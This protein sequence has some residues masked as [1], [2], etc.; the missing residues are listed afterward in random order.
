M[1]LAGRL[2][3]TTLNVYGRIWYRIDRSGV[4]AAEWFEQQ[5]VQSAARAAKDKDKAMAVRTATVFRAAVDRYIVEIEHGDPKLLFPEDDPKGLRDPVD[6]LHLDD[7]S[8]AAFNTAVEKEIEPYRTILL[9]LPI[10]GLRIHEICELKPEKVGERAVSV[11]GKGN[12][13]RR[14]PLSA[15]AQALLN[16]YTSRFPYFTNEDGI[17]RVF[18]LFTFEDGQ[19]RAEPKE[20]NPR[21]VWRAISR[22]RNAVPL[23]KTLAI[24]QTRHT[25]AT[26]ML[27]NGANLKLIQDT[28]GHKSL[29]T[30]ERYLHSTEDEI[31]EQLEKL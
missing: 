10:T 29:R 23:L 19:D 4:T 24:H 6:R 16:E 9:L 5:L 31:R 14:V 17:H 7:L 27:K 22:I 13:T 21:D 18:A 11:V 15:K 2:S 12:A 30:L 28:L 3:Q 1:K 26:K 25:T 20:C 8:L